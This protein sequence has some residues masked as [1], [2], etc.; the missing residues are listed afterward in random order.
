M[1]LLTPF[2]TDIYV[3]FFP[4]LPKF[5]WIEGIVRGDLAFRFEGCFGLLVILAGFAV[6]VEAALVHM[7]FVK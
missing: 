7:Y 1:N 5:D 3:Y 6:E 2:C 4:S